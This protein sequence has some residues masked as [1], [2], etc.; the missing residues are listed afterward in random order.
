M[1]Q[2]KL[3]TVYSLRFRAVCT[4]VCRA[5]PVLPPFPDRVTAETM[6]SDSDDRPQV[7]LSAASA[8]LRTISHTAL[9]ET[10]TF[11]IE[12]GPFRMQLRCEEV[13][14]VSIVTESSPEI[15]E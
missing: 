2:R 9:N 5:I 11:A 14:N 3:T 7:K 4:A 12:K 13:N 6:T 1:L 8:R 10:G 15:S